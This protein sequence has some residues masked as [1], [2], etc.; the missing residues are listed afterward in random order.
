MVGA[1]FYIAMLIWEKDL[2]CN[3]VVRE[4]VQELKLKVWSFIQSQRA[5][6]RPGMIRSIFV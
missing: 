2:F 3:D 1:V 5:R 6:G 4:L